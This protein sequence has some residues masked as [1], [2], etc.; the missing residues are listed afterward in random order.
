MISTTSIGA[1]EII[2]SLDSDA[3]RRI[4]K[5]ST[6]WEFYEGDQ[7]SVFREEGEELIT[8]NYSKAIV[9]KS[10]AFLFGKG[11]KIQTHKDITDILKPILDEVFDYND[12]AILGVEMGQMGGVTGD[13]FVKVAWEEAEVDFDGVAYDEEYPEGKVK[14]T[15]L[16]TS[17]VFPIYSSHD[18]DRMVSCTIQYVVIEEELTGRRVPK[19]YQEVITRDEIVYYLD[20]VETDRVK[21]SLREINIV[22]IKNMPLA[23]QTYGQSDLKS[24]IPLQ[25]ELNSKVTDV[26]DIINY[27]SAP[28][29]IIQGAKS[30][31]LEKGAKKVWGG[32]PKDSKVYNLKLEGD[33]NASNTFIGMTKT[34]IHELSNTPEDS[35]GGSSAISNTTGVALQIKYAPL[36]EKTWLKRQTYGKGLEHICRLV[37][38]LLRLKGNDALKE[39]LEE[40]MKTPEDVKKVYRNKI[41]FA[42]PLPKDEMVQLQLIA[43]KINMG[44]EE[45]RGALIELGYEDDIDEKLELVRKYQ[46]QQLDMEYDLAGVPPVDYGGMVSQFDGDIGDN[47]LVDDE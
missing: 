46:Q 11:F 16:P 43:Q 5:L 39:K 1:L 15:V 29:T 3:R 30:K 45:P 34:A 47:D 19:M 9:D 27:H 8:F 10:V 2:N 12:K 44:I 6:Y 23:G 33:L 14:I 18:K 7:W 37:I 22:H 28:V 21:N 17:T 24:I 42:D 41:L 35:L 31:N 40:M 4:N 13:C 20:G 36:L 38:K 26:S 25:K 32:L